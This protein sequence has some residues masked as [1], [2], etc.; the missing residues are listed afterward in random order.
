MRTIGVDAVPVVTPNGGVEPRPLEEE[1]RRLRATRRTDDPG[2]RGGM[3][4][5]GC[6]RCTETRGVTIGGVA[7]D[8]QGYL[9][10]A[11]W[12][13]TYGDAETAGVGAA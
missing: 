12:W 2:R 4:C 8:R 10:T 9:C 11:C 5:R 7:P 6:R 1:R 13:A 3:V